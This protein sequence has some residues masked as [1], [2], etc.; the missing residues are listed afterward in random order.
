MAVSTSE[1]SD[2]LSEINITPL[3]D[4]MLVLL[5]AF[6]IT[7]PALTNAIHINLPRTVNTT[8]P[9][10]QKAITVTVDTTGAVFFDDAPVAQADIPQRLSNIKATI[11]DPSLHLRADDRV[12]YGSVAKVMAAIE[13]SGISKVSVLTDTE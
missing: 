7:I 12:P 3:V 9:E 11:A 6:V 13:H 10:Q 5:V 2:V 1:D 4:V 8:P